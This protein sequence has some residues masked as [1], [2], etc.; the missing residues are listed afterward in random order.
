[1]IFLILAQFIGFIVQTVFLTLALWIMILIQ[2]LDYHF[3]GLLGSAALA[4]AVDTILNLALRPWFDGLSVYISAPIFLAVLFF[5]VRK[6]TNADTVDVSFTIVVGGAPCT[7]C[8]CPQP[9]TAG[10]S[11]CAIRRS[12][13]RRRTA[14]LSRRLGYRTR[15]W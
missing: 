6:V 11:R 2:K 5:C 12:K 3:L 9:S 13:R 1:M 7:W 10:C 15:P 4:C 14:S 8:E